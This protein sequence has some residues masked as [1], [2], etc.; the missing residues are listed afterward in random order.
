GMYNRPYL[1]EYVGAIVRWLFL[2]LFSKEKRQEK[3]L[4][5]QVLMGDKVI[6]KRSAK[7]FA[8]N[9]VIGLITIIIIVMGII[10]SRQI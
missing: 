4:F 3:G 9:F 2:I 10:L 7:T 5:N 1:F 8:L 6:F